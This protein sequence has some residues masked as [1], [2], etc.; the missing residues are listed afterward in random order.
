M[1]LNVVAAFVSDRLYKLA[2]FFLL[3]LCWWDASEHCNSS[4]SDAERCKKARKQVEVNT[5]IAHRSQLALVKLAKR[6]H[7]SQSAR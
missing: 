2:G 1:I 3:H 4:R 6:R 7:P 5:N